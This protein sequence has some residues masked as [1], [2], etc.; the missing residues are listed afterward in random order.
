LKPAITCRIALALQLAKI[1]EV[2]V[3]DLFQLEGDVA[4]P[5]P[6]APEKFG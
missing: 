3:E 4:A 6:P 2:R 1:L 5:Q